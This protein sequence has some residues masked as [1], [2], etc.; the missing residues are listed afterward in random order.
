MKRKVT[1]Q[2]LC[3]LEPCRSVSRSQ[4]SG[5]QRSDSHPPG[6]PRRC[7][8][9]RV[10][11]IGLARPAVW[12][13]LQASGWVTEPARGQVCR[14]RRRRPLCEECETG[15]RSPVPS[16]LPGPRCP[17]RTPT[18]AEYRP[19][20]PCSAEDDEDVADAEDVGQG[21]AGR[22]GEDVT[23]EGQPWVSDQPRVLEFTGSDRDAGGLQSSEPCGQGPLVQGDGE[24]V[25][26]GAGT[27]EP[28]AGDLAVGDDEPACDGVGGDVCCLQE[29][30]RAGKHLDDHD[31]GCE[32][33]DDPA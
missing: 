18:G 9:G 21:K 14:G 29:C 4:V 24:T 3:V 5:C 15:A 11:A 32:R 2:K 16:L 25:E 23:E 26:P 7:S 33:R 27:D 22:N 20:G 1:E 19:G 12:D 8:Q 10:D 13:K 28:E 30:G 6:R 31:L 17:R